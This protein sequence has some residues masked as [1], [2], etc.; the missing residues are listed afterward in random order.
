MQSYVQTM[1]SNESLRWS[2]RTRRY[3]RNLT[4]FR[5]HALGK[6]PLHCANGKGESPSGRYFCFFFDFF[7][8]AV[9]VT[10]YV[11]V[12]GVTEADPGE[13]AVTVHW[14]AD[15]AVR[16]LPLMTQGPDSPRTTVA[17]EAADAVRRVF[18]PAI[19]EI[20]SPGFQG[21]PP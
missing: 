20:G 9:I 15:S 2:Q 1:L 18:E 12:S 6:S 14:P 5:A 10:V 7:G 3:D 19:S 11:F 8:G 13:V 16:M 21:A 17:P 4:S